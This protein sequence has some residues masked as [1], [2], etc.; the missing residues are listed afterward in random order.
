[1]NNIIEIIRFTFR[2]S[3]SKKV[4]L[5]LGIIASVFILGI[6]LIPMDKI[7]ISLNSNGENGLNLGENIFL[8]FQIKFLSSI[9]GFALLA[10]TFANSGL[11]SSIFEKGTIDLFLSKPITRTQLLLGRYLGGLLIATV[12]IVYFVGGAWLVS[13]IKMNLFNW[14]FSVLIFSLIFSYAIMNSVVM[15]FG[16]ITKSGIPG[17]IITFFM[18]F[19]SSLLASREAIYQFINKGTFITIADSL[20]YFLPKISQINDY[21]SSFGDTKQANELLNQSLKLGTDSYT[22]I[23]ST[24]LVFLFFTISVSV[25]LINNRNF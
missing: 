14:Y 16:I 13:S 23:F 6:F 1:M 19:A 10:L 5:V 20:Y 7:S 3:L 15:L 22:M 17:L 12:I 18:Y 21:V 2:E 25:K 4:F 8:F 11:F 9:G 24:S